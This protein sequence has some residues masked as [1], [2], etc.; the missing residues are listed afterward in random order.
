MVTFRRIYNIFRYGVGPQA[1]AR[2][3]AV[4]AEKRLATFESGGLW[5]AGEDQLTRR[6]YASYQEYLD[7]QAAKLEEVS[8][9]L[10]ETAEVDLAEFKRRFASCE[11]LRPDSRVLCLGARRGTEVE[12][13]LQL[14]HFA[15]GIDLNPGEGNRFVLFGDFHNLQFPDHSLDV[16]YT[17]V[18]DHVFDLERALAEVTR[19]LK[20]DGMLLAEI[21]PGFEE[22]FTPGRFEATHWPRLDVLIDRMTSVSALQRESVRDLGRHRRDQWFQVIMRNPRAPA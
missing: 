12:A 20:P 8:D 17:N 10:E 22:G 18:L 3:R 4:K 11:A 9:R 6:R 21:L 16:V 14:G 5:Q 7:H 1:L 19:V 15:V 2:K 13:F